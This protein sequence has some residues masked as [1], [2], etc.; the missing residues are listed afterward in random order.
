MIALRFYCANVGY[1]RACKKE[2]A[3]RVDLDGERG[4]PSSPLG[5]VLDL[6]TVG[7]QP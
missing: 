3:A 7:E 1:L 5:T 4:C 6:I 2:G